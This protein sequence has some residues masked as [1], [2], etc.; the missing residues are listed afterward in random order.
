MPVFVDPFIIIIFIIHHFALSILV[1]RGWLY[2]MQNKNKTKKLAENRNFGVNFCIFF[3]R[4]SRDCISI[5]IIIIYY[6]FMI[7]LYLVYDVI[8]GEWTDHTKE[9]KFS[10][11]HSINMFL[12]EHWIVANGQFYF[13]SPSSSSSFFYFACTYENSQC[14]NYNTRR[15]TKLKIT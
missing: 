14:V 1:A 6:Y 5:K 13:L 2:L 4:G 12:T 3:S 11:F 7:N 8:I 9:R 10:S 15:W